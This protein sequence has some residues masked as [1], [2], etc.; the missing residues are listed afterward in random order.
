MR[1]GWA[2]RRL[3]SPRS[4]SRLFCELPMNAD[5]REVDCKFAEKPAGSSHK[6]WKDSQVPRNFRRLPAVSFWTGETRVLR[7][8]T[9]SSADMTGRGHSDED[10]YCSGCHR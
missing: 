5:P 6:R 8:T 9:I 3:L 7:V 2:R 1:L 4:P 10:K